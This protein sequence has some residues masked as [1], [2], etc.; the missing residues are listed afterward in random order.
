MQDRLVQLNEVDKMAY[1]IQ[2]GRPSAKERRALL[3]HSSK[4]K[5]IKLS[6]VSAMILTFALLAKF[7]KLDF[8]I[9]GDN[10][11][12]KKAYHTMIDRVENGD[13]IKTAV[14]AF[15]EEV[16]TNADYEN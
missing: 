12:T 15:C 10:D 6:V 13:D 11:V 14:T 4:V 2:Y 7:G 5:V 1:N 8:M 16:L 3:E 9:P